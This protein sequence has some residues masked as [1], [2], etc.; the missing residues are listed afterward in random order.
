MYNVS[1][2]KRPTRNMILVISDT[3]TSYLDNINRL[4]ITSYT[5]TLL[6]CATETRPKKVHQVREWNPRPLWLNQPLRKTTALDWSLSV[7]SGDTIR[8]DWSAS[9]YWTLQYY[10][11]M[12]LVASQQWQTNHCNTRKVVKAFWIQQ[13]RFVAFSE[14]L[15]LHNQMP[16]T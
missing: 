3:L 4:K 10:K 16:L 11:C 9:K 6:S 8:T 5:S 15:F 14:A 1:I 2:K 13:N 7:I 12:H